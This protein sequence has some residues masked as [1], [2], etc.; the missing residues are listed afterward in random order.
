MLK[1]KK[2]TYIPDNKSNK[3]KFMFTKEFF[4]GF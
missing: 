2:R 1:L 4:A 3:N